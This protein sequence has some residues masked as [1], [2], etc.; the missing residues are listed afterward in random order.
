MKEI[1]GKVRL[2]KENVPCLNEKENAP[3][4]KRIR[5]REKYASAPARKGLL[6]LQ[7]HLL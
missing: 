1:E 6:L 2:R 7:F 5:P 4:L 3:L